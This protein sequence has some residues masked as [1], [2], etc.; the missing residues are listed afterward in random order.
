METR[1]GCNYLTEAVAVSKLE[2]FMI[3]GGES[4]L[5]P[6]RAIA[7]FER[8]HQ[9]RIPRIELITN[10]VWGRSKKMA[11]KLAM[12]LKAAGVNEVNMS[13]DAFHL[14]YIPLEY[15]LNAAMAS[16]KAGIEKVTWNVAIMESLAA[17]NEYDSRTAQILKK[18]EF[19]GLPVSPVN[20]MLMGRAA[21]NLHQFFQVTSVDGACV[22]DSIIGNPLKEPESIC[23]EPDG[24]VD[25]C[26][27]LRIGN[28]KEM[29]L[30]RIIMDYDWRK[31]PIIEI[32]VRE[33]PVGLR[34]LLKENKHSFQED[35]DIS[36][37]HFC[38]EI[39]KAL[40][41]FYP[42]AYS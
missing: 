8:A 22:G 21:L 29:P 4:M 19:T 9:L 36:K 35:K 27:H 37:C 39:R 6:E 12:K 20:I 34:R 1:E 38:V 31:N 2:S 32:L 33:G 42:D 40:K 17:E 26:W 13:V 25:V 24:S 16:V 28:A 30:S 11:E 41:R 14:Q 15:P 10:G 23:I 3:F 5:Y 7:I 18:L